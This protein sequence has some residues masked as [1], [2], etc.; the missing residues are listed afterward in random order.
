MKQTLNIVIYGKNIL[1][2]AE[3]LVN[4]HYSLNTCSS[5]ENTHKFIDQNTNWTFY[6]VQKEYDNKT[7]RIRKNFK[8]A[9]IKS[10]L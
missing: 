8:R 2:D 10:I 4:C 1:T 5:F 3:R 6:L 9:L 7:K